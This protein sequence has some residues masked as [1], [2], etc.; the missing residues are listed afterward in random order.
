MKK[1]SVLMIVLS[2]LLTLSCGTQ[3]EANSEKNMAL[4][5][6]VE[7]MILAKKYSIKA[8]YAMPMKG[9]Q[10]YLSSAYDMRIQNDSAYAHLP[11]F[12]VAYS[13]PMGSEGGIKFQEP[14][15]NYKA[16]KKDKNGEWNIS[17]KA[18]DKSGS[19]DVNISIYQNGKASIYINPVQRQAISF[20][21]ELIFD[22]K[23]DKNND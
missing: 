22:K 7:E 20:L 3:K 10:I 11:Y 17:F 5:K 1:K 23:L 21:G 4:Q 15:K 19:Y 18:N 14:M 9:K 16:S 6:E 13:A 8:N 2:A 12:G